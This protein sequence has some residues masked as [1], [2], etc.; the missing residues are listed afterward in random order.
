MALAYRAGVPLKDM[1]FVQYHPTGMPGTGILITE[2]TRGEGGYLRNVKDERFLVDYDYGVGQKAELGPRD[3]IS[4]AIIQEFEAGR[5]FQGKYGDY[6]ALDLTHLGE[7]K[8]MERCPSC[9]SWRRPTSASTP[10]TSTS[11]SARWST[12]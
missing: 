8:I 1:E 2:A 11:R 10:C 4:R 6:A 3:M 12:T 7:A 5:G 9:A